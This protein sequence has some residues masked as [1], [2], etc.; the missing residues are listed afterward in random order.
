VPPPLVALHGFGDDGECW[1][2]FLRRAGLDDA[3]RTPHLLAHGGRPMPVGLA[4]SHEALV[5]D[6]LPQVAAAARD[7]G[8]P[9]VLL[10]HSLGASTAAG[11]AAAAPGLVAAL[12]LEDPPW[13]P[14]RTPVEDAEAERHND[15][16]DWLVGLQGSDDDGRQ[17]W[18][19]QRHP[20][21]PD[22]EV[23]AWA[24]AKTRVDL[25]LFGADQH[26]L[27]RGWGTVAAQVRCPV[28][29]LRGEPE[30][31]AA[32]HPQV[33]DTLAALPGWQARTV[34]TA[35]HD[36]RRD[37]P[38]QTARAVHEVLAGLAGG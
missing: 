13:S 7:A 16:L 21:W 31:G 9:V 10:G 30:R 15:F 23:Q 14:A 22:D 1:R 17:G 8:R 11:V 32:C 27:R 38:Q 2:P 28:L 25:A 19:R 37:A 36:V 26:W 5:A 24:Q 20:G 4:F 3:T 33:A 29:L 12:V 34:T 35:G 6:V 18:V